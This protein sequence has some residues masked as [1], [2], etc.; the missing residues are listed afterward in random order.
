MTQDNTRDAFRKALGG[1]SHAG[2]RAHYPDNSR[3]ET[4]NT[5]I[6]EHRPLIRDG[7]RQ[8]ADTSRVASERVTAVHLGGHSGRSTPD[9]HPF[10]GRGA[11][12]A[13]PASG[14]SGRTVR[15]LAR[16]FRRGR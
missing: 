3:R 14:T 13:A 16:F 4:R 8:H 9:N 5:A 10:R 1:G 12:K 7:Q 11:A 6:D 2:T 15:G